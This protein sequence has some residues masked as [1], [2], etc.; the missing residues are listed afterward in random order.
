[1]SQGQGLPKMT[2]MRCVCHVAVRI[3]RIGY[4]GQRFHLEVRPGYTDTVR[5]VLAPSR[6]CLYH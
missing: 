2:V 3:L 6:L 1:M 4:I 5:L